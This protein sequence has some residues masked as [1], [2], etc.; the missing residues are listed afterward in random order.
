MR[1]RKRHPQIDRDTGA[2]SWDR[3]DEPPG[4]HRNWDGELWSSDQWCDY[5]F[6]TEAH[7]RLR[8]MKKPLWPAARM[9]RE[10]YRKGA[11]TVATGAGM[12][13]M[14]T[15]CTARFFRGDTYWWL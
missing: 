15:N 1:T 6:G 12:L 5:Y 2:S 7:F 14:G 11:I 4:H 10:L 9:A 8:K 13:G 3:G